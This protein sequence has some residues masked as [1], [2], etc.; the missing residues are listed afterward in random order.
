MR[1]EP[2][3]HIPLWLSL[4]APVAAV[5]LAFACCALLI[6]WAGAPVVAAYEALL[7]GA[8]GSVFAVTETL[9]RA[10]PPL[11]HGLAAAVDRK[12]GGLG[13]SESDR[14]DLGGGRI[15]KK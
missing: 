4:A 12:R 2:R 10:A 9:T 5:A 8:F 14:V 1:L 13:Q 3:A 15:H 11:F 7:R 6:V